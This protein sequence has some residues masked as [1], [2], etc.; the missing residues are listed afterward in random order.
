MMR[1]LLTTLGIIGLLAL[2]SR[3]EAQ[4]IQLTGPLAGAPATKRL[5]EYRD[6]RFE[7]ALTTSFTLLDEYERGIL[8][9]V[10]L[11][12]NIFDWLGIGAWGAFGVSIPTDLTSKINQNSPSGVQTAVNIPNCGSQG[13]NVGTADQRGGSNVPNCPSFA[14]QTG[15]IN[16]VIAPQVQLVPFR[17]KLAIFQKIFVD[18]DAYLHAG[19]AFVGISQRENCGAG[20]TGGAPT[21]SDANSSDPGFSFKSTGSTAI[22][23]TFG[24]GLNFYFVNFMSLGVE[25]R[26]LPFS[27]DRSGFDAR[28]AG[29]N[30]NFPDPR[31]VISSQDS[32]FKFNQMITISLGF[33]LPL[34]PKL[35]E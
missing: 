21:C 7:L 5:R 18:T 29:T 1:R 4:E 12:Y 11:Q 8:P 9:G 28:G 10:R 31:G 33:S 24:L 35:S 30:N 27:W 6:G 20:T 34:H 2:G 22:A 16:W 13:P 3:A 23:P 32:T 17:G 25:Y 19:V 14:S 26:A 15:K